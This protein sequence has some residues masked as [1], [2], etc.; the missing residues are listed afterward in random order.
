MDQQTNGNAC[1]LLGKFLT[2]EIDY[3][4]SLP[5]DH[6]P[7]PGSGRWKGR[8]K[9]IVDCE[10]MDEM[11]LP[12]FITS[13]N[14]KPVLIRGFETISWLERMTS[15]MQ[16]SP[17]DCSND[18][19]FFYCSGEDYFELDADNFRSGVI[20]RQGLIYLYEM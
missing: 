5:K 10:N 3:L 15:L 20:V 1:K 14:A 19:F 8:F 7:T 18:T 2:E 9:V 4:R 12:Y 11:G 17:C 13:Y 6:L 16:I